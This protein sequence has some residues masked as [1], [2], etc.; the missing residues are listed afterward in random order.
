LPAADA[1]IPVLAGDIANGT[2]AIELFNDWPFPVLYIAG[3]HEFYG[4]QTKKVRAD[5]SF[6][7]PRHLCRLN[8]FRLSKRNL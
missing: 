4:A 8:F 7:L 5:I 1:D 3:N 2:Q 6:R